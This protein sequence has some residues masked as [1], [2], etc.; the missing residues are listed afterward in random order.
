MTESISILVTG[1]RRAIALALMGTAVSMLPAQPVGAVASVSQMVAAQSAAAVGPV[2]HLSL[3]G[4]KDE[5]PDSSRTTTTAGAP[6]QCTVEF[7]HA[8]IGIG[9]GIFGV[10]FFESSGCSNLQDP[11]I[12]LGNTP[13]G[14]A[15]EGV[16]YRVGPDTLRL[17]DADGTDA[18]SFHALEDEIP[19]S[20]E[21]AWVI[22]TATSTGVTLVGPDTAVVNIND[23]DD[24]SNT[25]PNNPQSLS[26]TPG[27][28][29]V[30]LS[31]IPPSNDGGSAIRH[32]ESA[33]R[34]RRRAIRKAGGRCPAAPTREA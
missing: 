20:G 19:E 13:F 28:R 27:N 33:T 15:E 30:T 24:P 10:L 34:W 8:Y 9:E 22:V 31:W 21:G 3:G 11:Y 14:G 26:G 2:A 1:R 16:D 23:D 25:V 18:W 12:I 5:R 32:Y 7:E 17:D 29:H 6:Q 4:A